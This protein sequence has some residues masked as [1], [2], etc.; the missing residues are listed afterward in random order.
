MLCSAPMILSIFMPGG[1]VYRVRSLLP[2]ASVQSSWVSRASIKIWALTWFSAPVPTTERVTAAVTS[3]PLPSNSA[4]P[5][6]LGGVKVMGCWGM[7]GDT[8]D[9][10]TGVVG[11]MT[12][13]E[14]ISL[15]L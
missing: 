15:P 3:G 4:S 9:W 1:A 12:D 2:I 13:M 14:E 7:A 6:T 8:V 10:Q 5:W 11:W